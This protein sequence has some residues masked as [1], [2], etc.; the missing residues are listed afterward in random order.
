MKYLGECKIFQVCCSICVSC[1]QQFYFCLGFLCV[2]LSVASKNDCACIVSTYN[3]LSRLWDNKDKQDYH[4]KQQ[5]Q[6]QCS[7]HTNISQNY[8]LLPM[9]N[10]HSHPSNAA[11][12]YLQLGMNSYP[13]HLPHQVTQDMRDSSSCSGL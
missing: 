7:K 3:K 9:N 2:F 1:V 5:Q 10:F 12:T 4:E 13:T 11:N 6:Q 8:N